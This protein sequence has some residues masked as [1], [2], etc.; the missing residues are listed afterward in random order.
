MTYQ[1]LISQ[2]RDF[3]FS[4]DSEVE[5]FG[6][7]V[8]NDINQA[9]TEISIEVMPIKK[10]HEV[11]ITDEDDD[12]KYIVMTDEVD[13]FLDFD[14][15][16]VMVARTTHGEE[17]VATPTYEKF[18]DFEIEGI[19]T[20][21]I[22]TKKLGLRSTKDGVE[23]G[24]ILRI[25]Y[26]ASHLNYEGISL[27]DEIP[28]PKIT[29]HLVPLLASYYIWLEDEPVKAAQYYNRYE[30]QKEELLASIINKPRMRVLEGGI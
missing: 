17:T 8:Q 26:K 13:D 30:T 5:D 3:G 28:L 20:M 24:C 6:E 9:I 23:V 29:H 15:T 11:E 25:N 2:I 16:P 18:N 4:D 19:D 12:Y 10:H 14:E 27:T 7:L 1:Q 21:V 22:N